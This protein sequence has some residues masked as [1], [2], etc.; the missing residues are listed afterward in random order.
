[1]L[2]TRRRT[3]TVAGLVPFVG[4]SLAA[5]FPEDLSAPE[6]TCEVVTETVVD[7]RAPGYGNVLA[8][9][10]LV[11][12]SCSGS[13]R[14][15]ASSRYD[16]GVPRGLVCAERALMDGSGNQGYCCTPQPTSCAYDPVSDCEGT[17]VGYECWGSNRPESLN[18]AI[19]CSNGIQRGQLVEYCCSGQPEAPACQQTDAVG[20]SDR[21]MGFLCKGGSLPRGEQLGPNKSRADYFHPQCSVPMQAPNPQYKAYC[22]HMPAV[23][24]VGGTC[25]GHTEVPGCAPGR[26]GFA[27]YGPDTPADDYLVMSCPEAGFR[28]TSAEGYPATLYCCDLE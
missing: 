3:T 16:E 28:G 9:T 25:V 18:A 26:F 4:L 14:P 22:C 17:E 12:Y 27:C 24:P 10:G 1:M 6:G 20:C 23:L 8:P 7:C 21:L 5:C 11:G 15:D 2:L 19:A 13:A